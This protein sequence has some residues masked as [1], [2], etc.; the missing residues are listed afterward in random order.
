VYHGRAAEPLRA[1]PRA[2]P[3]VGKL[4]TDR[5]ITYAHFVD[6]S[7]E[8]RMQA[9]VLERYRY[10]QS[11]ITST[12]EATYRYLTL[13]QTLTTAV[14]SGGLALFVGYK[15]WQIA[16]GT[17]KN[18]LIGLLIL[19]TI[20]ACFT[21]LLL[22]AGVASWFDYRREEAELLNGYLASNFREQPSFRNFYRW[23]ET[24]IIAFIVVITSAI[25]ILSSVKLFPIM[26]NQD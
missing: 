1:S 19:E 26:V 13:Y 3:P 16:G 11:Q 18:G 14:V 10:L 8:E 25:W 7:G 21:C 22:A 24:Y 15:D 2:V 20:I 23:Y 5:L 12:N 17:A 9:V 4:Q 6:D